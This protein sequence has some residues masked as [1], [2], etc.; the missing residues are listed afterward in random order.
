MGRFYFQSSDVAFRG[1][2]FGAGTDVR[3][4]GD[5]DGDSKS[6]VSV[7][8]ESNGVWYR[9]NS[10]KNGFGFTHFGHACDKAAPGDYDNDGKTDVAVFRSGVWYALRS[11][12]NSVLGVAYGAP[13]DIPISAAYQP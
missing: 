6:D 1:V 5:Y 11:G 12:N 13:T 10:A 4:V 7:F 3:A 8:R 9:I 2:Q